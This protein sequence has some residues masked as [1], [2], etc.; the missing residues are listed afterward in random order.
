MKQTSVIKGCYWVASVFHTSRAKLMY[1]RIHA[2]CKFKLQI[3]CPKI[4][5]VK[6]KI[7]IST[8]ARARTSE[9]I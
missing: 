4:G 6:K 7:S 1:T 2:Y 9:D 5:K 8:D 3:V